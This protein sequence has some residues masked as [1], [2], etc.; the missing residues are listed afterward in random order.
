MSSLN[1]SLSIWGRPG[2]SR[3]GG[4]SFRLDVVR[5]Q[6]QGNQR[7]LEE[8]HECWQGP[9]EKAAPPGLGST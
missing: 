8:D 2:P 4:R 3:K 7:D 6:G 9:A 1:R 5:G